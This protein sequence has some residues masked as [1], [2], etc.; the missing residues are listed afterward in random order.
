MA[1]DR[2]AEKKIVDRIVYW[3]AGI[4]VVLII[5]VILVGMQYFHSSLQP[6]DKN[7][8]R[9]VEV[10]IPVGA[11]N[12]EIGAILQKDKVIKSGTVFSYYVKTHNYASFQA[13]YYSL[14]PSLSL[15]Q[16][17]KKLSDGG[18]MSSKYHILVGEGTTIDQIG[19]QIAKATPYSKK[20]FLALMKNQ[21]YVQTLEKKYPQLLTSSMASKNVRYHLE[22]YLFPATYNYYEGL[23]LKT[24]VN[25]MVAKTNT[26]MKPYYSQIK[27]QNL[28]V[29]KVLTL[30]SLVEREGVTSA[31]RKKIAGVFFNR[32]DT[33]MPLQS[34]ISVMYALNTHKKHLYNKDTAVKS[35][36]NLYKNKGYGPGPFNSP[37][38][39]SIYAVM[40]PADRA[41]NYLYFVAN[42]KTGK[43]Y[44]SQTFEQHTTTN[45]GIQTKNK[46]TN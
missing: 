22:G 28:T 31:D 17:T 18:E 38:A 14:K 19:D 27:A 1:E 15:A 4:L 10:S 24:L 5:L 30:A 40:H 29:Q 21:T 34:D 37:S 16:V 23:T 42:L 11:S 33:K 8:T 12:K 20:E 44:Y 46:D 25:S 9:P 13:G 45:S 3:I 2:I 41:Q 39:S 32:I 26:V 6:Y 35:P 36:Y 7:A 43:V